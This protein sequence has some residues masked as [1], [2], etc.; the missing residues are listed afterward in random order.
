MP[1]NNPK[2]MILCSVDYFT[3]FYA[4]RLFHI[5]LCNETI[6]RYSMQHRQFHAT[7]CN[8]DYFTLFYATRLFYI[9]LCNEAFHAILWP[10]LPVQTVATKTSAEAATIHQYK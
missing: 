4:A 2:D 9:I 6:S 1:I 5:I 3:L 7:L 8:I 10:K